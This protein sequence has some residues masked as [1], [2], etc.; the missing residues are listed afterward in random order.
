MVNSGKRFHYYTG[1]AIQHIPSSCASGGDR[2]YV[3]DMLRRLLH[4]HSTRKH[5]T[6]F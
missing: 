2:A 4:L 3:Y 6:F 1:T 5:C